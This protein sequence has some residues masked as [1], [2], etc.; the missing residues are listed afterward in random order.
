MRKSQ[1]GVMSSS[2]PSANLAVTCSCAVSP[3]STKTYSFGRDSTVDSTSPL[4]C[5]QLAALAD[6]LAEDVVLPGVL[7]EADAAVVLRPARSP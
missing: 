2:L 7:A 4:P 5:V 1:N 6:P 3:A